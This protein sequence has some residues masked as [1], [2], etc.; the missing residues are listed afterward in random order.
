M[1]L[2]LLLRFREQ[3]VVRLDRGQH[4]VYKDNWLASL[5]L[6]LVLFGIV[7]AL[8]VMMFL[9]SSSAENSTT[10]PELGVSSDYA[11]LV[12]AFLCVSIVISFVGYHFKIGLIPLIVLLVALLATITMI[13]TFGVLIFIPLLFDLVLAVIAIQTLK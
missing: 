13:S 3:G 10:I 7:F 8:V 5:G 9:P 12:F 1:L 11:W 4:F 6:K 2:V